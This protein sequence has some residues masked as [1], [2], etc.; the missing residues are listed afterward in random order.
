MNIKATQIVNPSKVKR[1]KGGKPP[2]KIKQSGIQTQ[3]SLMTESSCHDGVDKEQFEE[4]LK[5]IAQRTNSNDW[6]VRTES[7]DRLFALI[8]QNPSRFTNKSSK[9]CDVADLLCKYFTD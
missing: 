9:Q 1:V 4:A 8:C 2:L 6:K 3:T 5:E 7:V